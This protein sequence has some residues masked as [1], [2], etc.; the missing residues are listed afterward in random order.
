M[1][2][3]ITSTEPELR[4]LALVP[5]PVCYGLQNLTLAFFG[6]APSW[7][8]SHFLT[9]YWTDGEFDRRLDALGIPHTGAWMGMFSRKLD[10]TNLAMTWAC[11]KRLPSAWREFL[12]LHHSFRP[13]VVYFANHHEIILFAPIVFWMRRKVV[14]HMHD[15]PPA[16]SFQRF[17]FAVWSRAVRRFLFVSDDV[18]KRTGQLGRLRERDAVIYNGVKV[19][20]LALPRSRSD[21]FCRQFDWPEDS[22]VFGMTGQMIAS[23]GHE[24]F[25][26]AA[27]FAHQSNAN[28]RFL[29][30]GRG[31][32][33]YGNRLKTMVSSRGLEDVVSFCGWLGQASDFYEGIDAIVLASR[34]DE[35]FGLVL[36]E[37]AERGVPAIATASGG[38]VGIV[39]DGETGFLVNKQSPQQMANAMVR[40]ADDPA[41]RAELALGARWRIEHHFDVLKQSERFARLLSETVRA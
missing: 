39:V 14:C 20:P 21:R 29:I 26:E 8:S 11:L 4:V 5:S 24:D 10:S 17:S 18:R 7:V 30:G 35:G 16:I 19:S 36:A 22:V 12:R 3:P 40:M 41:L 37:A 32:S 1:T 13:H 38:A 2:V 23:K 6:N 25:I 28:A 31:S 34:H 33:E 27:A 15:P 9:T